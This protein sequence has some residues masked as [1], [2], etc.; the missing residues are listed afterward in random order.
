MVENICTGFEGTNCENNMNDCV[1]K[2]CPE[3]KVCVHGINGYECRCTNGLTGQNCSIDAPLCTT[4]PCFNGA[5]C[6]DSPGNYTCVCA[7]GFT[8]KHYGYFIK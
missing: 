7:Q 5:T 4:K 6:I 3:D 8:G 2:G 1:H